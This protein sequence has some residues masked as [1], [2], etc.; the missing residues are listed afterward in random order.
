[1]TTVTFGAARSMLN[2]GSSMEKYMSMT[3][4]FTIPVAFVE[5]KICCRV[6]LSGLIGNVRVGMSRVGLKLA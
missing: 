3:P 4:D 5:S 6:W 2:T 1:M